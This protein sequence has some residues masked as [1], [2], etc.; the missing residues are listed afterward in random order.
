MNATLSLGQ[1]HTLSLE[2]ISSKSY[3]H[4]LLIAT[5]L[6]KDE[7]V[8]I[9]ANT[10][11]EDM[12]ATI[13][14]LE[15]LTAS[16]KIEEGYFLVEKGIDFVDKAFLDCNESGSTARFLLPVS[17]CYSNEL[18]MTGKGKLPQRPFGPL[19]DTLREHEV[20]ITSDFLPISAR[21]NLKSGTYSIAGDVSSQF[22]SGLLFALPLLEGDSR[23][24]LTSSLESKGYVDMTLDVLNRFGISVTKEENG[25][26][27]PGGQ[28]YHCPKRIDAE[29]DWSNGGYLLCMG[30]LGK[31]VTLGG[32]R[33]DSR[34]QDR[35]VV[36][37]LRSFGAEVLVENNRVTVSP[38]KM[39]GIDVDVTDIPDLVP[40]LCIVAAYAEGESIFR[41]VGRLRIKESDRIEAIL[42]IM[43]KINVC[44]KVN[45]EKGVVNLLIHG[46]G[47][48]KAVETENKSK[49]VKEAEIL[50]DGFGDHRIV[51]AEA[52]VSLKEDA[53]VTISG[54]EAVNKSYP[55]FFE[56]V[57]NMGISVNKE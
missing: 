19:N 39:Q 40:A 10:V 43:E 17:I 32:L 28:S 18:T 3:V 48:Q 12:K 30:A 46:K 20:E 57:S 36:D 4:R 22:I 31:G 45:E 54:A 21:G 42:H 23:I 26:Y 33:E 16:I 47:G 53:S 35:K 14:C 29:G 27:I 11:S 15:A 49:D 38:K 56:V 41:N 13:A 34:Q 24:E 44:A 2:A 25:Y 5:A 7:G 50:F 1:L 37:I 9:Y 8:K 52:F 6:S 51:M 55:G